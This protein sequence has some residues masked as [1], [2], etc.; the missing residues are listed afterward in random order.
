[1]AGKKVRWVTSSFMATAS[2]LS[3]PTPVRVP[4]GAT[5]ATRR[6]GGGERAAELPPVAAGVDAVHDGR[7]VELTGAG[8]D[9]GRLQALPDG[10]DGVTEVDRHVGPGRW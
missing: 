7:A 6:S 10:A 5:C 8:V 1:M 9:A 4:R 2:H 3:Q